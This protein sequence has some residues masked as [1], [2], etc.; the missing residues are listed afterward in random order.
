MSSL[1]NVWRGLPVLGLLLQVIQKVKELIPS[2]EINEFYQ[3]ESRSLTYSKS[4]QWSR[5]TV[6]SLQ[7]TVP[8]CTSHSANLPIVIAD[9]LHPL[10]PED[11]VMRGHLLTFSLRCSW[12]HTPLGPLATLPSLAT[13]IP[14][15]PI[16]MVS[17]G[18]L[19]PLVT[20]TRHRDMTSL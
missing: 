20:P 19:I 10:V 7:L 11:I 2:I 17:R 16:S 18:S 4:A 5:E 1:V 6:P 13:A 15:L 12:V 14:L 3:C 9:F 8:R